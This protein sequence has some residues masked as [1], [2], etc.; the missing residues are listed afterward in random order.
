M[1]RLPRSTQPHFATV[2][3]LLIAGA[4]A[5]IGSDRFSVRPYYEAIFS[6]P[7]IRING[8][9]GVSQNDLPMVTLGRCRPSA[10]IP[11]C[12]QSV[13]MLRSQLCADC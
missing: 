4:S 13:S 11:E 10:E 1:S 5:V 9:F 6:K 8:Y 12:K 7:A 3:V 2:M